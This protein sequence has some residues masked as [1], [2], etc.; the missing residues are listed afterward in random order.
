MWTVSRFLYLLVTS[1]VVI[2]IAQILLIQAE[3]APSNALVEDSNITSASN[4]TSASNLST[5][6]LQSAVRSGVIRARLTGDGV[7]TSHCT[8]TLT[9][10]SDQRL[11]VVVPSSQFFLPSDLTYQIMMTTAE[12]VID[13]LPGKT[14]ST[15]IPSVCVSPKTVKAP[16]AEGVDY[17]PNHHPE[18]LL[19]GIFGD[20]LA[21]SESLE[22]QHK[23]DEIPL[24]GERRRGTIAQLAIW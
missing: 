21:T 20:I 23:Y 1:L 10:L 16:P 9:N 19:S 11:R 2:F 18:P 13:I 7:T 24:A 8:L 4:A 15:E 14:V 17:T 5:T 3:A 6:A 22:Q 12:R